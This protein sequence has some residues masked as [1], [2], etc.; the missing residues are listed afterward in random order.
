VNFPLNQWS[1]YENGS[2]L[3]TGAF[4]PSGF[5]QSIRFNYSASGPDISGTALDNVV[6]TIPEPEHLSGLACAIAAI[7]FLFPGFRIG[8]RLRSCGRA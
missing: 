3:D 7:W 8:R 6:V 1:F 5:M 2:L 4:N